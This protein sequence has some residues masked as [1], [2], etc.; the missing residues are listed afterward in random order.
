MKR[1]ERYWKSRFRWLDGAT[2]WAS[3]ELRFARCFWMG[4]FFL[5]ESF[6][7]GGHGEV[8]GDLL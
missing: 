4:F 6:T 3:C 5:N 7:R 1:V 8:L 2:A